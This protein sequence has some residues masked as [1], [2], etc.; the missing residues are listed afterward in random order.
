M[1][2]WWCFQAKNSS[3]SNMGRAEFTSHGSSQYVG[4]F[5][6]RYV[7]ILLT[8]RICRSHSW[9]RSRQAWRSCFNER[10]AKPTIKQTF[11]LWAFRW[12]GWW[13]HERTYLI[14]LYRKRNVILYLSD[15]H[16][17]RKFL[18][19][20]AAPPVSTCHAS[21]ITRFQRRKWFMIWTF[22]GRFVMIY[23][24]LPRRGRRDPS[25]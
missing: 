19:L 23:R 21:Q 6:I 12:Y 20:M 22:R 15:C 17:D 18:F 2:W 3:H 10:G 13:T 8:R 9:T 1:A 14:S 25:P 7:N 5:Y 11:N 24:F 4:D 16:V